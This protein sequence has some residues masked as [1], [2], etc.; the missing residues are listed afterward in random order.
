MG[1]TVLAVVLL[2][3]QLR[4]YLDVPHCHESSLAVAPPLAHE[5]EFAEQIKA[6]MEGAGRSREECGG[7]EGEGL[8]SELGVS[9]WELAVSRVVEAALY[10]DWESE[11]VV[12]YRRRLQDALDAAGDGGCGEGD[13]E[14]ESDRDK[15]S[16]RESERDEVRAADTGR[17]SE[18]LQPDEAAEEG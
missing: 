8:G 10:T 12:A 2:S 4:L 3:G 11:E 5:P 17:D 18:R 16:D 9:Q 15:E 13:W 14:R 1:A 7:A 6:L